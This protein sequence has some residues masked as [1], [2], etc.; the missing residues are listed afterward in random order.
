MEYIEGILTMLIFEWAAG[1]ILPFAFAFVMGLKRKEIHYI[2]QDCGK[3]WL[4]FSLAMILIFITIRYGAGYSPEQIADSSMLGYLYI[5]SL[6]WLLIAY[7][8]VCFGEYN[9]YKVKQLLR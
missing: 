8:A 4:F 2:A 3:H 5:K 1:C 6:S 7:I 9:G